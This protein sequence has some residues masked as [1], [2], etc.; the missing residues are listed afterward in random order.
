ML[1][2]D[3]F[4]FVIAVLC[5]ILLFR[6]IV[7]SSYTV[8]SFT[9]YSRVNQTKVDTVSL[10]KKNRQSQPMTYVA[11]LTENFPYYTHLSERQKAVFIRR[12]NLF[13]KSHRFVACEMPEVTDEMKVLISATA[14]QL[15]FGMHDFLALNI[16]GFRIYPKEYYSRLINSNLKGHF[17]TSGVIFL[18]YNHF[19][20]GHLNQHDGVNL[21]LH[22][23]AHALH[24]NYQRQLDY[25]IYF[26]SVVRHWFHQANTGNHIEIPGE[27]AGFLR[28][29]SVT[30]VKEFFAVCVENFFERP[31]EFYRRLPDVY[32]H[33]CFLLN[34]NPLLINFDRSTPLSLAPGGKAVF[35]EPVSIV[36]QAIVLIAAVTGLIMNYSINDSFGGLGLFAIGIASYS[37]YGMFVKTHQILFFDKHVSIQNYFLKSWFMGVSHDSL[38]YIANYNEEHEQGDKNILA[39]VYFKNGLK[40]TTDVIRPTEAFISQVESY[41]KERNLL[42]I[43]A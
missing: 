43:K 2:S 6:Y 22:E 18:A 25:K 24:H 32:K 8:S 7:Q 40:E 28:K 29:Y 3:L 19:E 14:I 13:I 37:L 34:Q 17:L 20:K 35:K 42:F 5:I 36:S 33:L 4:V 31:D 10:L 1:M 41:C 23:M 38:L 11:I 26:E 30:N 9:D 16:K 21:G 15:T 12:L 27:V 39:F